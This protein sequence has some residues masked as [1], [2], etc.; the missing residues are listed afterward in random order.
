MTDHFDLYDDLKFFIQ[1]RNIAIIDPEGSSKTKIMKG[2]VFLGIP[3]TQVKSFDSFEDAWQGLSTFD[4]AKSPVMIISEYDL[5]G[6]SAIELFQKL[7]STNEVYAESMFFL[8]I[9][10]DQQKEQIQIIQQLDDLI[11]GFIC[12]PFTTQLLKEKLNQTVLDRIHMT[13]YKQLVD[14]AKELVKDREYQEAID[15]LGPAT[16]LESDNTYANSLIGQAYLGLGSFVEAKVWFQKVL[17]Q[18]PFHF[19]SLL[20]MAQALIKTQNYQEASAC[21]KTLSKEFP[22]TT[23]VIKT[24]VDAFLKALDNIAINELSQRYMTVSSQ[25]PEAVDTISAGLLGVGKNLFLKSRPQEAVECIENARNLSKNNRKI[26]R[27]IIEI[28][29]EFNQLNEAKSYLNYFG[30]DQFQRLEFKVSALV[31]DAATGGSQIL[32]RCL[33]MIEG[34]AADPLV[35][36]V[37]ILELKKK[38]QKAEMEHYI[39]EAIENYPKKKLYFDKLKN[40]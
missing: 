36:K 6:R 1:N 30:E 20:G 4:S 11:N 33:Q 40:E 37:L 19:A 26:L 25:D 14:Q 35:Y 8:L 15:I 3:A 29:V 32:Q 24:S 27:K 22:L 31:L 10:Q 2:V 16:Q 5:N 23:P 7:R 34:D 21:L 9:D 38:S 39:A 18:K 28:L 12:K 17:D 13:P